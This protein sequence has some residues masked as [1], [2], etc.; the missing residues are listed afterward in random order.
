MKKRG[1]SA[2]VATILI[3]LI[4]V[5][6][7]GIVW[8][9]VLPL[10][11]EL[12]FLSYS[13][14]RLN[15]VF[16]GHTVYDSN[17][18]FAFVQ[19]E[20]GK[21]QVNVTGVEIGFNFDGMTKTYQS[22]NVPTPNGKYTYKFNFTNDSE[23][24][25]PEDVAPDKVT[26]APIFT[27]NNKVRLGKILDEKPMPS[28]R[29]HLSAE[30]WKKA[31]DEAAIPIVVTTGGGDGDEPGEE[32]EPEPTGPSIVCNAQNNSAYDNGTLIETCEYGCTFGVCNGPSC[33]DL[34]KVDYN[35]G[36]AI[37]VNALGSG[38]P[39]TLNQ[40]GETY[41]LTDD[42][43]VSG[44]GIIIQ[45]DDI[46][47]DMQGYSLTGPTGPGNWGIE[48][49]SDGSTIMNGEVYNFITG[50]KLV[51][52]QNNKI[53]NM[54]LSSPDR[55]N[56]IGSYSSSYNNLS[57]ITI[58][59]YNFVIIIVDGLSSTLS[60]IT[61]K[62]GGV[63]VWLRRSSDHN[64][65]DVNVTGNS[66]G[67]YIYENSNNNLLKNINATL[68][69]NGVVFH[70]NANDNTLEDSFSCGNTY[71]DLNIA[72]ISGDCFGAGNT[73]EVIGGNC[74]NDWPEETTHYTSC[75]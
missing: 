17:Q 16:Q 67:I 41:V 29:I 58:D 64:L 53:F 7:V 66:D 31:N 20:R 3:I 75:A 6:G 39:Y 10:F 11:A 68:N 42:I 30:A 52:N 37:D 12:E 61:A 43:T 62:N 14:V 59:G 9:V 49:G 19:I 51:S 55:G 35:G 5:V 26:V 18:N 15:I 72:M 45:A 60:H 33:A 70:N 46:I 2:V 21:D 50:I 1:I 24:G 65:T 56:G 71:R 8:K 27:I 63:G 32:V 48:S 74:G 25:I 13:D 23:F 36:C 69:R 28:G 38:A 22:D 44:D 34:G 73:L 47:L 40:A 4:V 54:T 57:Q